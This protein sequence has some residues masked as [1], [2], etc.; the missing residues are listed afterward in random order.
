[1]KLFRLKAA[2]ERA[3]GPSPRRD[4]RALVA[5]AGIA[6]VAAVAAGA[7]QRAVADPAPAVAATT[8]HDAAEG[9]RETPHVL[10]YYE[11]TRS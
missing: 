8:P 2:I 6:G 10:R 3:A 9:Y 11:T 7:L 1:M 5:G 4:R